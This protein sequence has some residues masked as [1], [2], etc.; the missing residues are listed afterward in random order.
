MHPSACTPPPWGDSHLFHFFRLVNFIQDFIFVIFKIN[1]SDC[2]LENESI[3]TEILNNS[4]SFL[5][6]LKL[7]RLQFLYVLVNI[8]GLWLERWDNHKGIGVTST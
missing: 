1:K 2:V 3:R 8:A 4:H 5:K 6:F 7:V